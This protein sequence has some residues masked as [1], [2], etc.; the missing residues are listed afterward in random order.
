MLLGTALVVVVLLMYSATL[1]PRNIS[2]DLDPATA[3]A[4]SR[5]STLEA[6]WAQ[7][8]A[9]ADTELR[10]AREQRAAS[11]PEPANASQA[12]VRVA[13]EAAASE[14]VPSLPVA[15]ATVAEPV[16][17]AAGG[18]GCN[19]P[20]RPYHT[21]LTSSSGGYQSWQCR[22]MY[23]HWKLQKAQDP[24]GEMGGFTRLLTTHD[25]R[26][27]G[28]VKEIPTV[29]VKEARSN[30]YVVVNRPYSMV[31]FVHSP[32]FAER[33]TEEYVYIAETDHIM[34]RPLPNLA[35]PTVPVAFNFGY[36]VAWGQ[37]SIVDKFVPGLGGKTDPVGPSPVLIHVAQ[38]KRV[39]TP[40]HDFTLKIMAD[41]EAVQ[42]LGWVREMWGCRAP[43]RAAP[44]P[45]LHRGSRLP[46]SY[47]PGLV[48]RPRHPSPRARRRSYCIATGSLGIK[49]RVLD[50][51]QYEGGSIGNR[52][53]RLAWPVPAVPVTPEQP[54]PYYIFHYTYGIEYTKEG[55]P[56][57]LQ[58]SP[59]RRPTAP[60]PL[61]PSPPRRPAAPA[62]PPL[63]LRLLRWASGRWTS[64][65]TWARG[66]P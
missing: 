19:V 9:H 41:G 1:G 37:A 20:P 55:L 28:L 24:C 53:R 21:I 47:A 60:L 46:S 61:P 40:W 39:V 12:Q 64:G 45:A 4:Q 51:L 56:V 11:P 14:A 42:H 22:I 36:M 26:P 15:A 35:T 38:L 43:P 7:R 8:R 66:R 31:Q 62:T 23:H 49:H 16:A 5:R 44:P 57:E 10:L 50:A 17:A 29:V 58:A 25:E 6:R 3:L 30:G 52:E 33:V 65:T 48:P 18:T 13:T 2:S 27:D 54:M 59:L 63:P 34:L 32:K